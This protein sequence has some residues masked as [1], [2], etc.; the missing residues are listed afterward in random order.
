[1]VTLNPEPAPGYATRLGATLPGTMVLVRGAAAAGSRRPQ[2]RAQSGVIPEP[3][4]PGPAARGVWRGPTAEERS[5]PPGP[6]RPGGRRHLGPVRPAAPRGRGRHSSLAPSTNPRPPRPLPTPQDKPSRQ[7]LGSRP[8]PGPLRLRGAGPPRPHAPAPSLTHLASTGT[9]ATPGLGPR[10]AMRWSPRASQLDPA[11]P[12]G[13]GRGGAAVAA[14]PPLRDRGHRTGGGRRRRLPLP[15]PRGQWLPLSR[16]P[17]KRRRGGGETP[18]RLIFGEPGGG[19]R[20]GKGRGR[21]NGSVSCFSSAKTD[22]RCRHRRRRR[23]WQESEPRLPRGTAQARKGGA[24]ERGR[25]RATPEGGA[26]HHGTASTRASLP[27]NSGLG[28]LFPS[29]ERSPPAGREGGWEV[30]A[31]GAPG[32]EKVFAPTWWRRAEGGQPSAELSVGGD[33]AGEGGSRGVC[34]KRGKTPES[35]RPG[36]AGLGSRR[37]IECRRLHSHHSFGVCR[38]MSELSWSKACQT[39]FLIRKW[40]TISWRPRVI[41]C[42]FIKVPFPLPLFSLPPPPTFRGWKKKCF[43]KSFW[44]CWDGRVYSVWEIK[45]DLKI[46][47]Y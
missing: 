9:W 39:H 21:A 27:A 10:W 34:E 42:F 23:R 18:R 2:R 32:R 44:L 43:F 19:F 20:A 46:E 7:G 14:A 38:A 29:W 1:M 28:L 15:P 6:Q 30:S 22:G 41:G 5:E 25:A 3:G 24:P 47:S 31:P 11:R 36:W 4:R 13:S 45:V 37:G 17:R 26:A 16:G 8:R 33:R 40:R 12:E 35:E